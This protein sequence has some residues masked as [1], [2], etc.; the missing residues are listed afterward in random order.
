[1]HKVERRM[2]KTMCVNGILSMFV[3]LLSKL[4]TPEKSFMCYRIAKCIREI[5]RG[6]IIC[7]YL[8]TNNLVCDRMK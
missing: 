6:S 3:D 7:R 4:K 8:T 5:T 1:M 2:V